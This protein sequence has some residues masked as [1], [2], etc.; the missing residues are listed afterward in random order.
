MKNC[1]ECCDGCYLWGEKFWDWKIDRAI[2]PTSP[3][4]KRAVL[5]QRQFGS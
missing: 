2:V 4:T 5:W 1:V 3:A